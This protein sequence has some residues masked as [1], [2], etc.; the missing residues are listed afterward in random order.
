[1]AERKN[2]LNGFVNKNTHSERAPQTRKVLTRP[3]TLLA[4][5]LLLHSASCSSDKS[6]QVRVN[7]LG[8][9][10]GLPMRAYLMA[11]GSESGAKFAVK[12]SDGATLY[13]AD[14]GSGLGT[15]GA[16]T[17][18]TL[19]FTLSTAGTYTVTVMGPMPATSPGFRVETAAKLYSRALANALSFYQNQRDGADY[20][21]SPLRPAPAHL[22]DQK[23]KVYKT[24][25]F[26]GSEGSRIKGDLAPNG[27]VIDAS[28]G[29]WDAGD[30]LKFVETSSYVTALMLVGV[31]DFPDQM[32][33]GSSATDFVNEAKFGLD[34]LLRMW[35]DNS[36]TL[37]YQVGIGSWN[38]NYENDHSIWRLAQADDTYHGS[39]PRYRYIRNRPVLIAAPAGSRISPNLAGRLSADFALCYEV[40][41]AKDPAYANRCLL[42]AQHIFDLA[43]NEPGNNLLT[44]APHEFYPESEWR[45]DME[46]GATELYLATRRGDLPAGL[47]HSDPMFY[48]QAAANWASAYIHNQKKENDTLNLYDIS[49]LAHFDLWRAIALAGSPKSLAVSQDNLLHDMRRQLDG[50]AAE[51]GR[52]PF[53]FG[54]SWGHHDATHRA[55]LSVMASEY[56]Y[57]TQANTF[58]TYSGQWL[59][60]ILGANPWGSSFIV[61]DGSTFPHCIHH[62]VA[63]LAGA[64]DGQPPILAG[65][66]VGGPSES[67]E[68]GAPRGARSCPSD[69]EDLFSKFNGNGAVYKDSV[70]FYSTIEPAID[71]T[72]PSFLMFAWRIA[73]APAS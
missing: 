52:D 46:L 13:S 39:D 55:G 4:L 43:D 33:A 42:V 69:G 63:N 30:Y 1:M 47:P 67:G 48:L 26:G 9:E 65:A 51:E 11:I 58:V 6:A 40:Y 72:A 17:L 14:I 24:P 64:H 70:K 16:Y 53:G 23:A 66:L 12:N 59:A 68:S 32:G 41:R 54:S 50:A 22:N 15:W 20:I 49:G 62:Q 5:L 73:R 36:R 56:D 38:W 37:Y 71:L 8:Y 44:T 31:R 45:D 61:G 34:W 60:N 28:G 27:A 19:D 21:P 35:D 7:Q 57:L 3:S 29:W 2:M 18:Y 25:A 10:S